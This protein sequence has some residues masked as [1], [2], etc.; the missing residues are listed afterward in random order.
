MV[1]ACNTG[2]KKKS[3]ASI[4]SAVS[5]MKICRGVPES[6]IALHSPNVLK[7]NHSS[8][9]AIQVDFEISRQVKNLKRSI[10]SD[11]YI[12]SASFGTFD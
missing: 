1:I 10:L 3:V 8:M 9:H 5:K 7:V 11:V 12:A 4:F 2:V 6:N